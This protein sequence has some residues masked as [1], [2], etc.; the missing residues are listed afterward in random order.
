MSLVISVV[1]DK[2]NIQGVFSNVL[3]YYIIK[4]KTEKLTLY[5]YFTVEAQRAFISVISDSACVEDVTSTYAL[6]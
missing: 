2:N 1:D 6:N 5:I 3:Y 4:D